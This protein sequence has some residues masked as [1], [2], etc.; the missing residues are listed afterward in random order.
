MCS[1][2]HQEVFCLQDQLYEVISARPQE[3]HCVGHIRFNILQDIS[4]L[5]NVPTHIQE[6]QTCTVSHVQTKSM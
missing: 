2:Y 3:T 6:T 5:P 4:E 1:E